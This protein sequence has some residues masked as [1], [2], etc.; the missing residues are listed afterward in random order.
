MADKGEYEDNA[1]EYDS[2]QNKRVKLGNSQSEGECNKYE[3]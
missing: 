3:S 1:E 2:K